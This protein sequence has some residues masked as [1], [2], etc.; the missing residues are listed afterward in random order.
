MVLCSTPARNLHHEAD[1]SNLSSRCNTTRKKAGKSCICISSPYRLMSKP[2]YLGSFQAK[3]HGR[4]D[5]LFTINPKDCSDKLVISDER[6]LAARRLK[7]TAGALNTVLARPFENATSGSV[8]AL[9]RN[10]PPRFTI[11]NV[12]NLV[13]PDWDTFNRVQEEE[14]D[15]FRVGGVYG[16]GWNTLH[17]LP[18]SRWNHRVIGRISSKSRGGSLAALRGAARIHIA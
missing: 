5:S 1:P 14:E 10:W 6:A 15:I 11:T 3:C 2:F 8:G 7:S 4:K 18:S 12:A 13:G 16:G 17:S 9:K